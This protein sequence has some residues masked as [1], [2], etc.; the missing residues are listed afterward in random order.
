MYNGLRHGALL[1]KRGLRSAEAHASFNHDVAEVDQWEQ[2]HLEEDELRNKV[3][4]AK[5]E[6]E[7]ALRAKFFGF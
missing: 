6:Y 2:V 4:T 5:E 3:K 7:D 1:K